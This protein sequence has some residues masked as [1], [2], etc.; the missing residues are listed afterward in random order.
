MKNMAI[1][2]INHINSSGVN[3]APLDCSNLFNV[4]VQAVSTGTPTVVIKIQASND[5]IIGC[6]L[7][8]N[9]APVPQNWTDISGA[10][11][12][13][14]AAGS[15]LIPKLDICYQWIRVVMTSGSADTGQTVADLKAL[16]Y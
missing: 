10:T 4:S 5:P 15:F 2:V 12:S 9:G 7:D 8:A 11:V 3:G 6:P 14:G 1:R 16:G 13:I